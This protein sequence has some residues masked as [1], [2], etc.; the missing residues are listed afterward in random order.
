MFKALIQSILRRRKQDAPKSDVPVREPA[1]SRVYRQ[2]GA[3]S[4]DELAKWK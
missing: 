3:S 4:P 1:R 2:D